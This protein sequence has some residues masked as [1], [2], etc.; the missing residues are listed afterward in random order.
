MYVAV[1]PN[2]GTQVPE[3]SIVFAYRFVPS[4]SK[5][6]CVIAAAVGDG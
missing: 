5:L 6:N 1:P 3:V 4:L 2:E